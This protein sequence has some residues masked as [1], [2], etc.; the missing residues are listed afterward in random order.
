MR[1][2]SFLVKSG[3]K[4][5]TA[6]TE[7]RNLLKAE[8]T[9]ILFREEVKYQVLYG[10]AAV[11][12]EKETVSGDNYV[13]SSHDGKFVMCLSDGMGSG[14][15]ANRES[16]TV[17]DLMEQLVNTGFSKEAAA[18]LINSAL[19]LQRCDGMFSTVDLC[20]VDLY[21]GVCEFLKAGAAAT[22]IRRNDWVETITST[23]MAAGLVQQ[24]DFDIASK[25][26]YDGEYLIMVTD[27]VLDALPKDRGEETMKEILLQIHAAAP[28]ELGRMILERVMSFCDYQAKDDMT[29][30]VAGMWRI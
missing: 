13:C 8:Y 18:R 16:E 30:L 20:T 5:L 2:D 17:V 1:L 24:T 29:V 15:D 10:A 9:T 7:G 19:V 4:K 11:T 3:E 28:R 6:V 23:S 27:G 12:K 21:T 22:F 26:L 25:K 14:L